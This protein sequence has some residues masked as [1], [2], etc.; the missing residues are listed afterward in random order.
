MTIEEHRKWLA[1]FDKRA[2]ELNAQIDALRTEE[3]EVEQMRRRTI[4][5]INDLENAI[6][7]GARI[8][9]NVETCERG[10]C[11]YTAR[12]VIIERLGGGCYKVLQD[13]YTRVETM[14]RKEFKRDQK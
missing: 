4:A 1:V 11:G 5:E 2:A 12:G 7:I 13:N 14:D 8:S 10:C 6:P 3:R 9:W